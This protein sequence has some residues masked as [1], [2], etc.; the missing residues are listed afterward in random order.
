MSSVND[1]ALISWCRQFCDKHSFLVDIDKSTGLYSS[2]LL[3]S[4]YG[5]VSLYNSLYT[6]DGICTIPNAQ[7]L[8]LF[9]GVPICLVRLME[10]IN[11]DEFLRLSAYPPIIFSGEALSQKSS[12]EN[13]GYTVHVI[14]NTKYLLA[15]DNKQSDTLFR[16]NAYKYNTSLYQTAAKHRKLI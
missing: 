12:F 11:I 15:S 8:N 16:I 14:A 5:A 13:L 2:Q 7:M 1:S 6:V 9:V 10:N 3:S 4:C